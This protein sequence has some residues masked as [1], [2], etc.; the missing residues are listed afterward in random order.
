MRWLL[1]RDH[2]DGVAILRADSAKKVEH[3]D[4]LADGLAD[5]VEGI[6][7]LLEAAGV[8][9]VV[10]VALNEIGGT[11]PLGTRRDE[12]HCRGIDPRC[13]AR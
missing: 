9:G 1:R 7:E 5:V 8:L 12:A 13:R 10:Y 2:R 11:R 6:D 3:L 4:C